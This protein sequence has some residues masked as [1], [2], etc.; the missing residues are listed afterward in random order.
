M[1]IYFGQLIS[2]ILSLIGNHN[3]YQGKGRWLITNYWM[4]LSRI[5]RIIQ[6]E[7]QLRQITLTKVWII[8]DVHKLNPIIVLL[9]IQNND[10]CKKRF[11]VEKR[12]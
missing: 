12:L 11:A 3:A 6:T 7:V 1:I 5:S 10:R 2:T 9:Y 4:R 8:L